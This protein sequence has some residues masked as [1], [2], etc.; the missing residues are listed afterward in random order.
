MLS[1][2]RVTNFFRTNRS[3]LQFSALFV[4]IFA[5]SYL[6]FGVLPRSQFGVINPYTEFLAKAVAAII[7]LFGG[8][9][10]ADGARVYSR[11]YSMD[12]AMGCDGVEASCLYL[13]GVMAFPTSWRARLI[14]LAFGVPLIQAIN[15]IRIVGLYYVGMDLP[16]VSDQIH[17]YVAQ[18]LVILLSTG[19]L[20]FWFERFGVRYQRA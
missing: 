2:R 7:N 15:L 13:A 12:I 3:Q 20:L 6:A 5:A 19:I 14:G 9:V 1:G 11:R 10:V 4:L 16:S 18:T 17:D 8:G